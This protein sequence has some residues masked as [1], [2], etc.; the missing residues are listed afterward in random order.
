MAA[1]LAHTC[2]TRSISPLFH[3]ACDRA[4]N[5]L[6]HLFTV[7][8]SGFSVSVSESKGDIHEESQILA[9]A[10]HFRRAISA[11]FKQMVARN[12]AVLEKELKEEMLSPATLLWALEQFPAA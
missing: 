8:D 12:R 6:L 5:I 3:Q 9:S 4:S 1:S 11:Q 2:M 7:F 10:P